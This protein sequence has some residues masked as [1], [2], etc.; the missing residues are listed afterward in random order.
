MYDR[1]NL[2]RSDSVSGVLMQETLGTIL[3]NP[4]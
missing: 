1:A 2:G 4:G 3:T